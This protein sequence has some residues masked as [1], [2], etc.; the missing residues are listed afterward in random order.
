MW[1]IITSV[2]AALLLFPVFH[3]LK[4]KYKRWAK[5]KIKKVEEESKKDKTKKA[6][7]LIE[8]LVV[9]AIIGILSSVVL[10]SLQNAKEEVRQK[11]E[12]SSMSCYNQKTECFQKCS[13]QFDECQ[14]N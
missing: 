2:V 7:T 9:M 12:G 4:E 11:S 5:N 14:D 6:F 3:E 1:K 8:L 13:N 10:A